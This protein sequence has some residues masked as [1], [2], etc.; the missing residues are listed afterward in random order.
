M[1]SSNLQRGAL[2]IAGA[3]VAAA[4]LSSEALAQAKPKNEKCYGVSLKGQNDCAAGPGTT[5]AGTSTVNHQGNA[6]KY[7]PAGTC[8]KIGGTLEAHAGNAAPKP[9][10]A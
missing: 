3:L 10:K 9:K 6:W 4:T 7:V 5:C 8:L 1:I 2:A